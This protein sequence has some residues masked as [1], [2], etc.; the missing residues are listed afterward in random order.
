LMTC[1]PLMFSCTAL[2]SSA[3]PFLHAQRLLHEP[4][5][6]ALHISNKIGNGSNA[7]SVSFGSRMSMM[8]TP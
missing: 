5:A 6:D 8:V 1:M 2:L 7:T 4:A 3:R